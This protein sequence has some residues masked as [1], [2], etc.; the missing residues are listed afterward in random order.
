MLYRMRKYTRCGEFSAYTLAMCSRTASVTSSSF[1]GSCQI[2]SKSWM[3]CCVNGASSILC[4]MF[5]TA[6][7]RWY[8]RS[9]VVKPC[10]GAYAA[11]S[12]ITAN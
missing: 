4:T 8:P 7:A 12:S 11:V 6:V 9:A 1:S 3:Y 10:S 5:D 2:W